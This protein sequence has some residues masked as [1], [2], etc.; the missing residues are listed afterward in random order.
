MRRICALIFAISL[1]LTLALGVSAASNATHVNAVASVNPNESCN[2]TLTVTV[3]LD[4]PIEK[5]TFP[6]PKEAT[7]VTLNG[8]RVLTGISDG[9]KQVSL[10][11]IA[12]KMAGDFTFTITYRLSDVVS[13]N[14]EGFLQLQIPL[15]AG[16]AYPVKDLDFT[17]T[18]PG[19]IS[20]KP[21]FSSGYHQSNIEQ[22]LTFRTEGSS[23]SGSSVKELKDRETLTMTLSVTE[24]M[25]PQSVIVLQDYSLI[26]TLMI[27]SAAL[28]LLYW[29]LFL[30]CGF[31]RFP[32]SAAPADG[33][34]AGQVASITRLQGADL[35]MMVFTWAQLG[36]VLMKMD[37]RG[38]VTLYKRMD[39]GNERSSFEQKC[40]KLLFGKRNQV[41]TS[42][43][44]YAAQYEKI[45]KLS[46]NIHPLVHPKT[47]SIL[48]F[49]ALASCLGLLGGICLGMALGAEA[50][51]RGFIIFL[52]ALLGAF[53]SWHIQL[54]ANDLFRLGKFRLTVALLLC[55]VWILLMCLVQQFPILIWV[56]VAQLM[57][58]LMAAFGG[59]RTEA[60]RQVRNQTFGLYRYMRSLKQKDLIYICRQ[61]PDYFHTL[62]PYALAMG[63]DR[64]F[65]KR[66]GNLKLPECPYLIT[67]MDSGLT[68]TQWR[69]RMRAA[70]Y[71]MDLR[72]RQ[73]PVEKLMGIIQAL[74]K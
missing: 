68:A 11:R 62:A 29:L 44:H 74:R 37:K 61:N 70:A 13:T 7:A 52:M 16:F 2:V 73:M 69:K 14:E 6:V 67:G 42:G 71:A 39:M 21:A 59:R 34:T 20:A 10:S 36:Y 54:W 9:A 18:L 23:V 58:G 32:I 28:A 35:T 30:R 8:S 1:I 3:H 47:G 38:H 46:P 45:E 51:A 40:F 25:F 50:A 24:Q 64:V 22:Y 66:F 56:V 63:V 12:G 19:E 17:V 55:A 31:P 43:Y 41:D 27:V 4:Q 65:A 57:F 48:L 72:R 33:Y 15:L 60:G 49:R 5:L 53:S 26:H